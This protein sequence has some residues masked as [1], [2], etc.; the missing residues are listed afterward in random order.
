MNTMTFQLTGVNV[1]RLHGEVDHFQ[2][3]FPKELWFDTRSRP[4]SCLREMLLHKIHNV[5]FGEK[6][7]VAWNALIAA[8]CTSAPDSQIISMTLRRLRAYRSWQ[9]K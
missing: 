3:L 4:H 7:S 2:I 1:L 5:D 6:K 8:I 9:Y